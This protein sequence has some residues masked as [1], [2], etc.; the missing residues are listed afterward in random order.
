LGGANERLKE[1]QHLRVAGRQVLGVP[2][3]AND[4]W[5]VGSG[6]PI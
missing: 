4:K 1:G 3:H 6:K 2:L 5:H